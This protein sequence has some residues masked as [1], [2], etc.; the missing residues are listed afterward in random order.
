[1]WQHWFQTWLV[2]LDPKLSPIQA[3][4]LSLRL[5]DDLEIRTLNAAYRQQDRATDVLAFAALEVIGIPPEIWT[6]QPLELGDIVISVETAQHQAQK[7]GHS[8]DQELAWLACHGLLHLLGWDH[9]DEAHLEMMLTQQAE[10]LQVV[11]F[12]P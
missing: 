11:G 3:Y 2:C 4:A 7:Q 8:L 10:L 1:M 5:T 12:C 9:P 6:E